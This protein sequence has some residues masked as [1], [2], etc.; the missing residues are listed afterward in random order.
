MP[1]VPTQAIRSR[2]VSMVSFVAALFATFGV[3]TPAVAGQELF[4]DG[5]VV[6][7]DGAGIAAAVVEL[8]NADAL[9][10]DDEGAFRFEG[11]EAGT[12][13]LRVR[14]FGFEEYGEMLDLR[15]DRTITIALEE[16]AFELDSLVIGA[17]RVD[18]RG[19][20]RDPARDEDVPAVE[21]RT[22]QDDAVL[23]DAGGR[24]EVEAWENVPLRVVA[25]AFGYFAADT[26]LVPQEEV[27]PFVLE[28]TEDPLVQA[29]LGAANR[30]LE[31]RAR[32]RVSATM[33]ALERDQ[34]GPWA[35][36]TL[37]DVLRVEYPARARRVA[38]VLVDERRLTPF[39]ADGLLSTTPAWEVERMEFLFNGAMLRI[40]TREFMKRMLSGGVGL[41]APVY[42]DAA[43]PPFCG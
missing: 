43:R 31:A 8:G 37:D 15:M 5:R 35:G 13:R 34:I 41:A 9:L 26:L 12:Y 23:T 40:Y 33:P 24:C 39:E 4:L 11:I 3:C 32:G 21:I 27:D 20:V 22:S 42:V 7:G 18:V 2:R 36:N 19:R 30:R 6:D 28:L 14:A 29:M 1:Q 25:L 10:T 38:C 17:E 16:T